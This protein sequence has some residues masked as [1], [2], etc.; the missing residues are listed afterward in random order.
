MNSQHLHIGKKGIMNTEPDYK[1][2]KEQVDFISRNV[3]SQV[4]NVVGK[5]V[6]DGIHETV[7]DHMFNYV[8]HVSA[9]PVNLELNYESGIF[10][11]IVGDVIRLLYDEIAPKYLMVQSRQFDSTWNHI[12]ELSNQQIQRLD[13]P[14]PIRNRN[15]ITHMRY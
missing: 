6:L 4:N 12:P 14:A 11:T 3:T 7:I 9:N 1:L 10:K 13:G 2:S 8:I 5:K 15:Y